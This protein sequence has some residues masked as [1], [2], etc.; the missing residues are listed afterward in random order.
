MKK[1]AVLLLCAALLVTAAACAAKK[2]ESGLPDDNP[3][4]AGGWSRPDSPEVPDEVREACEKAFEKL[5]G[6]DYEPVALLASQVVAGMNYRV[7]CT[8]RATAP[9]AEAYYVIVTVYR[10]LDGDAEVTGILTAEAEA[11]SGETLMGG[12]AAPESLAVTDEAM[13]VFDKA[14]EELTGMNYI[15]VVL[16]GTQVVAGTNW[17][18]L[19]E[20]TA[21]SSDAEAGYA[22]MTIYADLNGGAEITEIAVFT[23]DEAAE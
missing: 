6:V 10:N 8:A 20:Q 14:M 9:D 4:A 3:T 7:L 11:P 12:W 5:I 15:P 16:V 2:P 21:V 18:L 1:I 23:A 13:D 19:C 17:R 22:L